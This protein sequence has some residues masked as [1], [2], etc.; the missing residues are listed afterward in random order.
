MAHVD[1]EEEW[2]RILGLAVFRDG[3]NIYHLVETERPQPALIPV[4]V[5]LVDTTPAFSATTLVEV[6]PAAREAWGAH[7]QAYPAPLRQ[8]VHEQARLNVLA[9]FAGG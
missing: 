9:A 6:S 7:L 1:L 8:Q 3:H 5:H 4:A 2:P